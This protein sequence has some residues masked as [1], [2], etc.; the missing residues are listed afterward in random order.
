[1]T[2]GEI[3]DSYIADHHPCPECGAKHASETVSARF[4]TSMVTC[5]DCE[6]ICVDDYYLNNDVWAS[7]GL[8][9]HDGRL[10]LKCAENRLGRPLTL[11]DFSPA[12]INNTIR[13]AATRLAHPASDVHLDRV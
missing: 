2:P 9:R 1:M 3:R 10:H 8:G 11:D 4:R 13:W 6:D 7:M 5:L 12:P